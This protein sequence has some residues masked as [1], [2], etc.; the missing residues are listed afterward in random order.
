MEYGN[1]LAGPKDNWL[2][3]RLLRWVWRSYRWLYLSSLGI[4]LVMPFILGGMGNPVMPI[5]ILFSA[6]FLGFHAIG[7][8][9]ADQTVALFVSRPVSRRQVYN[10]LLLGALGPWLI[11]TAVPNLFVLVAPFGRFVWPSPAGAPEAFYL[12]FALW[13]LVFYLFNT[14]LGC[15]GSSLK[16]KSIQVPQFIMMLLVFALSSTGS[17]IWMQP[18][19]AWA[20]AAYVPAL[21]VF[22]LTLAAAFYRAGWQ[23][24]RGLDL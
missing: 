23:R 7:G 2:N 17:K 20:T 12:L 14:C 16:S 22:G 8:A 9:V 19:I 5:I 13:V 6:A 10:L 11:L 21:T 1:N 4:S 18:G 3:P 15:S 24:F